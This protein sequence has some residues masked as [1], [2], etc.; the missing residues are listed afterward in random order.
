M[1]NAI[2]VNLNRC[3]GCFSCE[4][5]C[6]Q[7]NN[8]PLGQYWN[9]VE[10]VGPMGKHPH[11]QQY[12]LPT[13]CQ[14][15]ENAPCIEVCPTGASM[16]DPE[17][18]LVIIDKSICIGCKSCMTACP[19]GVRAFNAKDNTVGKC[20]CCNDLIKQGKDP[21]C[22]SICCGEAR[23]YGDLDDPNSPASKMLAAAAPEDIHH[24]KDAGNKPVSAYIL[25]KK[26]A[27]W[28]ESFPI[29]FDQL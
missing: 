19:Y 22:V 12:W 18:G 26:Y 20:I 27:T 13:M 3:I 23:A 1:R 28:Q 2:V 5:A 15:C 9:K 11:I 24:F 4:I 25:S 14:Q 10:I 17:T 16:R 8:V 7:Q 21:A 29:P 6:K